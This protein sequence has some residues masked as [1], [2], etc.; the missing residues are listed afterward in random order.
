[1]NV[2][3]TLSGMTFKEVCNE[4]SFFTKATK[5]DIWIKKI[6]QLSNKNDQIESISIISLK[7]VQSMQNSHLHICKFSLIHF[8][9]LK[10][11]F[12]LNAQKRHGLLCL[13]LHQK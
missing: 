6:I 9:Y 3:Q 4:S 8:F 12:I 1:M 13:N 7:S 10:L 2:Y 5:K 11:Q